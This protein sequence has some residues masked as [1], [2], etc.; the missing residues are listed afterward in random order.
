MTDRQSNKAVTLIEMT[1]VLGIIALLAAIVVTVTLRVENQSNERSLGS[2]FALLGTS[3]R[4]YYEFRDA[5][6]EQAERIDWQT[7]AANDYATYLARVVTHIESMVVALRSVPDSRHVLD[8]LNPSLVKSQT[9]S[10][11]VPEL[12]DPWGTV[13]DYVYVPASGDTFP[14]L[15]SAG[16]DKQFGTPDDIS[17]KNVPDK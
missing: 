8:Q 1:V 15:I 5:F 7:V 13:L 14:E 11:N 12:R 4:E 2:A 3:L 9:G 10:A 16:P 6:P 17:S